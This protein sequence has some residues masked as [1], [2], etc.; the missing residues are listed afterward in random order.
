MTSIVTAFLLLLS[1][2]IKAQEPQ[3][4]GGISAFLKDNIVYPPYSLQNCIQGTIDVGF[5]LNAKGEV[6]YASIV[7][8]I[9]T[10]LDD[11]ALRLIKLSSGKWKVPLNHDTLA[12]VL[13]PMSFSLRDYDCERKDKNAIAMA[14]RAYKIETE[15][16]N[17]IF[18]FYRNKEKGR[19]NVNEEPKILSIKSE[20]AIDDEYLDRRVSAGLKKLKQGDKQGACVDFNFVKYMGSDKADALLAKYCN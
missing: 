19:Y 14:T 6:Y 10:D 8:G 11:E 9:G 15:L 4:V 20:L 2:S 13:I 16:I 18:N 12:L 5:K 3:L 7:K 1:I 17:V